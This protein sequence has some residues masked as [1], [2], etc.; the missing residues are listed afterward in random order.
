[1]DV[2]AEAVRKKFEAWWVCEFKT[3]RCVFERVGD[4]YLNSNVHCSW[5]AWQAAVRR[6]EAAPKWI[7]I[8]DELPVKGQEVIFTCLVDGA[9]SATTSGWWNGERTMSQHLVMEWGDSDDWQPCSHWMPLPDT[10]DDGKAR[11]VTDGIDESPC[12]ICSC[13]V[14]CIPDGLALC[15]A[16][17]EA[18]SDAGAS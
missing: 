17:A 5:Q 14:N 13:T 16:C 12:R 3:P 7:S 4:V 9:F 6:C 11:L 1:M 10:P 2:E 8:V 15:K 18:Q